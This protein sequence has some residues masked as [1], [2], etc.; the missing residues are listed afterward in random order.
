MIKPDPD[1]VAEYVANYIVQR[2]V[3]FSPSKM[4]PFVLGLPM[5]NSPVDI[6]HRLVELFQQGKVSFENVVTFNMDEYVGLPRDHPESCHSFMW[7]NLFKHVDIKA[8]NVHLLDGNAE[9]LDLECRQYEET[10][11]RYGGIELLLSGTL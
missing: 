2:I 4:R 1:S 9:H 5:C 7:H 8:E 3:K 6:Y 11:A 10:I